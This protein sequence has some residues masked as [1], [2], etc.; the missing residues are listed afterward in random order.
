MCEEQEI[1][2][3]DD[4]ITGNCV[5][6]NEPMVACSDESDKVYT[7]DFNVTN[8]SQVT[9][10]ALVINS[11]TPG[12]TFTEC[13]VPS[14]FS[15][16]NIIHNFSSPLDILEAS[17]DICLKV[18]SSELL[19]EET[20]VCFTLSLEGGSGDE[21]CCTEA[22]EYCIT[23]QPCCLACE[24]VAIVSEEWTD[25]NGACCYQIDVSNECVDN[26]F[27]GI[28]VNSEN[29]DVIFGSIVNGLI[30]DWTFMAVDSQT[31]NWY[32]LEDYIPTG[33]FENLIQFCLDGSGDVSTV[34]FDWL[35][36]TAN[37]D[38]DSIFCTEEILYDCDIDD[39]QCLLIE[40]DSI[41]S[42]DSI[43]GYELILSVTN[44][45]NSP[46]FDAQQ[47]NISST[48]GVFV[49][50]GVTQFNPE[51]ENGA[52]QQIPVTLIPQEYPFDE[53]YFNLSVSIKEVFG[54]VCCQVFEDIIIPVPSSMNM[55]NF[56]TSTELLEIETQ[57][58]IFPNPFSEGFNVIFHQATTEKMQI[59]LW[60]IYG[61]ALLVKNIEKGT[62]NLQI[63]PMNL[64]SGIYFLEF[65][66]ERNNSFVKK[67]IKS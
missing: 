27:T 49:F 45:S 33:T 42:I 40:W 17:D 6:L 23:L 59:T 62:E 60:D 44:T 16:T 48:P 66:D 67:L 39:V 51:L 63:D 57:V 37:T 11:Q 31:I 29:D 36:E 8:L 32:P 61:R 7:F 26:F 1:T 20:V 55:C 50:G 24:S 52:T 4:I 35:V 12:I 3:C 14:M 64:S 30:G 25:A 5:Q 47:L 15:E 34:S 56:P 41:C 46:P 43:G 21:V 38:L 9:A 22:V 54:E 19:Q 13:F 65:R 28:Q 53:P 2:E 58:D 18:V 10:D